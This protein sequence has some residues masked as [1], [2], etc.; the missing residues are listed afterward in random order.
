MQDALATDGF[1]LVDA[2]F[3]PTQVEYWS[4]SLDSALNKAQVGTLS[5]RDAIYGSRNILKTWPSIREIPKDDR[6]SQLVG[7]I[8]GEQAGLVRALYFDKPPGRS[9]SLPWHRDLSI[10]VK[11]HP[12]DL[13]EYRC[14][15]TKAGI[16][17]VEAPRW[18]LE[19][20]LTVRVHLD[21]M[22]MENGPLVVI[23]GSHK[24]DT[25][26]KS[27]IDSEIT[28]IQCSA[29]GVFLMRPLLS[30]SSLHAA[31][32]CQLRRRIL[33]LEFAGVPNLTDGFK[34][35]TFERVSSNRRR[36]KA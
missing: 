31:K 2:L 33:H 20:M 27:P 32:D 28:T 10:A 11:G 23:P 8:L 5:S 22:M 21:P 9:W 35:H 34:W 15:T 25:K 30:H 19:R 1:C 29:G 24:T 16:P 13:G 12:A 7:D 3:D 6:I 18:L 4:A 14:P 36:I 26:H 17:H